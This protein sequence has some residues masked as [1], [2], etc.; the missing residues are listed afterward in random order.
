LRRTEGDRG[1]T[2]F[3]CQVSLTNPSATPVSVQ[4]DTADGTA[5]AAD[6]DYTPVRGLVLTF[7]PGGP[8]I[9]TVVVNVTGDTKVEPDETFTVHLSNATGANVSI[10][11]DT[12]VGTIVNDDATALLVNNL[13]LPEGDSGTTTFVFAVSLLNPSVTPVSVQVD[14]AD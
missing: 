7:N 6:G 2:A 14:T 5:T 12:G 13:A 8:W 9:Q 1:T 11:R 10:G 3:T 4:V